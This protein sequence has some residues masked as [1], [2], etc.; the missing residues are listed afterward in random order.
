MVDVL[1][2]EASAIRIEKPGDDGGEF[3]LQL[4]GLTFLYQH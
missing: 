2:G 3:Y 4:T 1:N